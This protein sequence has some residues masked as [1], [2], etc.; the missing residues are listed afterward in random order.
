LCALFDR[1]SVLN[2]HR[3]DNGV[4]VCMNHIAG[5]TDFVRSF[6]VS[7]ETLGRLEIFAAVLRQWQKT[8]NLVSQ[9]TLDDLWHRH[10]AD[11]AQLL[12]FGPTTGPV[13]WLDL[14]SGAGFPGLVVGIMLAERPGSRLVLIESDSRKCAFLREV[15]RQTGLAALV[16]V[17][18]LAER[19]ETAANTTRVGAVDVIS[20]RAVAPLDRLLGWCQPFFGS[21]TV[22]LLPKGRDFDAELHAARQNWEFEVVLKSSQ[23]LVDGRILVVQAL[24]QV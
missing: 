4:T 1:C 20:A 17:D 16:P 2:L 10:F 9:G 3:D 21:R 15:V 19:I 14:G 18:I 13:S 22:A 24:K 12:A 8:I 7:R 5:P 11:S 6:G 23:T